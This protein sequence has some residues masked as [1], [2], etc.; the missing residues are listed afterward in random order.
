MSETNVAAK[1]EAQ[2]IADA[3]SVESILKQGNPPVEEQQSTTE[4]PEAETTEQEESVEQPWPKKAE[5]ALAKAKGKAAQLR[6]ERD[7]ERA[8]R[9]RA[10]D[11]LN[12][13]RSPQQKPTAQGAP[14]EAD[15]NNYAEFLEAKNNYNIDQKFAERDG[16][17]KE[18]QNIQQE[19]EWVAQRE[20]SIATSAQEFIKENPDAQA[21]LEEYSDL[22]DEFSPQ[23]Q[24]LFLEADNAPLAFYNLAKEGKLEAL[25]S[26]SLAKAAMEIGRAQTQ[27]AIKPKT[28]APAPLAAS[29]GSVPASKPLDKLTAREAWQLLN[30]KD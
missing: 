12:K 11:E 21:V 27:A 24:R 5:N 14:K 28:K 2:P 8:A 22:A 9:Q 17:Q 26:M 7:Q 15:F 29:R 6:A 3:N 10:E 23:L 30:P 4:T 16:K 18:T 20:Q 25:A 13:Y 19:Q 1:A